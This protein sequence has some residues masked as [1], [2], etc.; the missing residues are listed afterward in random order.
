L[1]GNHLFLLRAIEIRRF[2]VG[3]H[4][5]R[6]QVGPP[7]CHFTSVEV[8]RFSYLLYKSYL[9]ILLI[10]LPVVVWPFAIEP[11]IS[12]AIYNLRN[13]KTALIFN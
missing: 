9:P 11:T 13:N 7:D 12:S 8:D 6:N 3:V 5:Q 10:P 1:L 4:H 2:T